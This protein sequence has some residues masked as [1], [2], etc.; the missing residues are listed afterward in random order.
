MKTLIILLISIT[1]LVI[2]YN[3]GEG[4]IKMQA[5][6]NGMAYYHPKT[7][8]FTWKTNLIEVNK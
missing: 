1:T 5:V 4:I 3:V 8:Q 7:A 6:D 2:G